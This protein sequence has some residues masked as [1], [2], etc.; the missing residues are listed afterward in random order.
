MGF[1]ADIDK[2]SCDPLSKMWVASET[3]THCSLGA[4][5]FER[6]ISLLMRLVQPK[7]ENIKYQAIVA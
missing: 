3:I 4:G 1:A 5:T 6:Q 7:A 2:R